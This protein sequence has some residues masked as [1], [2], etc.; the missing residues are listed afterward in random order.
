MD[1]LY[2][3][4]WNKGPCSMWFPSCSP[5]FPPTFPLYQ[6]VVN[7][8]ATNECKD[9]RLS[10]LPCLPPDIVSI[11]KFGKDCIK[12]KCLHYKLIGDCAYLVRPWIYSP[13]KGCAKS[14]EGYKANWNF[15]QSF[16]RM[17]VKRAFGILK[18]RWRI[19]MRRTDILL[20]HM[21]DVV[22]TCIVLRN[23]CTIGKNKFDIK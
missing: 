12:S 11:D 3:I 8:L 2:V 15:I 19:I 23:M 21:T 16:T 6:Q 4:K 9:Q 5:M 10:T 1:T 22:A 20:R 18:G 17:C 13:F 14:L 7:S